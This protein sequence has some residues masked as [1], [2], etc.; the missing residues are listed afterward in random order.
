[1]MV[2]NRLAGEQIY[3]GGDEWG[4]GGEGARGLL[5]LLASDEVKDAPT[6]ELR[7]GVNRLRAARRRSLQLIELFSHN[8][9]TFI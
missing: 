6:C 2:R 5:V 8:L 4:M 9:V 3:G 7:W 1:M